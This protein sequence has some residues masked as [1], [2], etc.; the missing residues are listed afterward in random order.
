MDESKILDLIKE[1][2]IPFTDKLEQLC[3][4]KDLDELC[5][6]L[7][8]QY[9]KELQI[10]DEKMRDME[11]RLCGLQDIFMRQKAEIDSMQK[12]FLV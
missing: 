11:D 12:S 3:T 5:S 8:A 10:R 6:K 7:G 4:K 2:L 1:A 9:E